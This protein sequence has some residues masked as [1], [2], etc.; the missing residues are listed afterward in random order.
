MSHLLAGD[1]LGLVIK[2]QSKFDFSYTFLTANIAEGCLFESAFANNTI[3]PL[4]LYPSE[5]SDLI[6]ES[7]PAPNFNPKIIP[8]I[9]EK[10]GLKLDWNAPIRTSLHPERTTLTTDKDGVDHF[11]PTDLLD[12]IYAVLHSPDY[13]E[14][15]KDL[16]KVDFPRVPYPNNREAFWKLVKTGSVLR[17]LHL[18]ENPSINEFITTYPINPNEGGGDMVDKIKYSEGKVWLNDSQYF[19]NVPEEAWGF[20]IGG[21]QPAQKYLKDRK[22]SRMTNEEIEQYQRIIY[23]LKKTGEV[24]KNLNDISF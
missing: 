22:G 12:Y 2:R 21:Y 10:L 24:M 13:R 11:T 8:Q 23:V 19:G 17:N 18:M 3:C 14:K 16:L 1:N 15:F 4:Y 5:N 20:Y 9:E 7:K 6:E